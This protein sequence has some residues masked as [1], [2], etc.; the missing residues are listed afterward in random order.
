MMERLLYRFGSVAAIESQARHLLRQQGKQP[1]YIA[2]NLINLLV[3]LQ[4]DLR[5]SDFSDLVVQQA[6][7]RQ[8]NLAG[9]NF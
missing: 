2:G 7:L 8:V 6:D 4:V 1:G 9:V 3:Q 5:G